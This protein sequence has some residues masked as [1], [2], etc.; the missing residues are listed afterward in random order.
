MELKIKRIESGKIPEYKTSGSAGADCFA[1]IPEPL[2]IEPGKTRIIPLGFSVEIPEGY[3]MQIRSR[4]GLSAKN[5]I[6][7]LNSPGTID[8]D[9][10]GEV[11]AIIH[12]SSDSDFT[13]NPD[14]RIAQMVVAPVV[15]V[16]F[17]EVEELSETERGDGGFGST[18][19]KKNPVKF[20]EPFV[21][22]E[23]VEPLLNKRVIVD[24]M[25]GGHISA[26]KFNKCLN[27]EVTLDGGF[28]KIE[29]TTLSA[30]Q[31]VR[32]DNHL[33]GIEIKFN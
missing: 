12:N 29:M 6:H 8:S 28:Q 30:F 14:D 24:G 10:R 33:F 5:G 2:I 26:V 18:G 9:Y 31:R 3:E 25:N 22:I 16:K 27:I 7:I 11:G 4:S 23:E 20:Y 21:K 17:Q 19:V 13:I 15:Q 32:I 1:R